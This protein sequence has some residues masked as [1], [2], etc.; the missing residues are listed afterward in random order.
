MVVLLSDTKKPPDTAG[1]PWW[2][3]GIGYVRGL[4][5]R[6]IFVSD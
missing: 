5:R 6:P 1:V 4:V 2:G 3:L